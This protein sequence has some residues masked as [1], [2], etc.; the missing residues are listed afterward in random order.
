MQLR[1]DQGIMEVNLFEFDVN[2]K[3]LRW[4]KNNIL[5]YR[6]NKPTL[7]QLLKHTHLSFSAEQCSRVATLDIVESDDSY[8]Q[9][10]QRY[11]PLENSSNGFVVPAL[12]E[13]LRQEYVQLCNDMFSLY[14]EMTEL[15][16]GCKKKKKLQIGD[17]MHGIPIEDGRYILPCSTKSNMLITMQG[18]SI[19]DFLEH[20][21]SKGYGELDELYQKIMLQLRK[22]SP[23]LG[24][25]LEDIVKESSTRTN[26]V[27]SINEMLFEMVSER[28]SLLNKTTNGIIRS[29]LGASTS[30]A[31]NTPSEIY[32]NMLKEKGLETTMANLEELTQ[33]VANYGH[34][35]ILEH[36]RM[37]FGLRMSIS[38]YHQLVRHRLREISKPELDSLPDDFGYVTPPTIKGSKFEPAYT[39][40]MER[41]RKLY[42]SISLSNRKSAAYILPNGTEIPVILSAN[43]KAIAHIISDRTCS[44]AQW[45][46]RDIAQKIL[47]IAKQENPTAY[48]KSGPRCVYGVCP[49]GALCCGKSAE[50]KERYGK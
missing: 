15:K 48:R 27:T 33:R 24:N 26:A 13:G 11:V 21:H 3:H 12:P 35:S 18:S 9:Q 49:E 45:E 44:R 14:K 31:S 39:G 17:Y 2:E 1:I 50:M 7:D 46:I 16:E 25:R 47:D 6:N 8:T 20:I 32:E 41:A 36:S 22:V 10:S 30:T 28:V 42:Q 38:T 29:G 43:D 37:T 4:L 34:T 5:K 40:L 23:Y 19:S